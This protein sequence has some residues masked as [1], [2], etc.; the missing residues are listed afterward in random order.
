[1]QFRRE[2]KEE[3]ETEEEKREKKNKEILRKRKISKV[4]LDTFLSTQNY[5]CRPSKIVNYIIRFVI[6][7]HM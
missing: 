4:L 1:M 7:I 5:L 6:L 3:E 2:E